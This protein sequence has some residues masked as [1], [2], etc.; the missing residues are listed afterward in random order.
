M[1]AS[2]S[3]SS[4]TALDSYLDCSG[5]IDT[6]Q[7]RISPKKGSPYKKNVSPKK[8]MT[9]DENSPVK[10]KSLD[11][12]QIQTVSPKKLV[13]SESTVQPV[14]EGVNP[15]DRFSSMSRFAM[16]EEVV[17]DA[18]LPAMELKPEDQPISPETRT[19]ELPG[20]SQRPR[21]KSP[22]SRLLMK[23]KECA[24]SWAKSAM[25]LSAD[26]AGASFHDMLS[27]RPKTGAKR[28][29]D[30]GGSL[31][32]QTEPIVKRPATDSSPYKG[33]EAKIV[34]LFNLESVFENNYRKINDLDIELQFTMV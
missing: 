26:S 21:K 9:N 32:N 12:H 15:V 10:N 34:K 30:F 8:N 3:G 2:F 25:R 33:I 14:S 11:S 31:T 18:A 27:L 7:K 28:R 16:S 17:S 13:F 29:L 5:D 6:D 1:E 20:P 23:E 4:R 24:G 19:E 22:Q